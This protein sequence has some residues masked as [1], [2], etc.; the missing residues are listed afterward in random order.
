MHQKSL[1]Y[2]TRA[3]VGTQRIFEWHDE[4]STKYLCDIIL[5]IGQ[6]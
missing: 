4:L 6:M 1:T 3:S 5:S 2:A